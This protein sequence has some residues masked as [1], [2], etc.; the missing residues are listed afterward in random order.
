MNIPPDSAIPYLGI[1]KY[2]Q[3]IYVQIYSLPVIAKVWFSTYKWLK[4]FLNNL[5]NVRFAH[6]M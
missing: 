6:A 1:Y 2:V 4:I 3:K 5:K